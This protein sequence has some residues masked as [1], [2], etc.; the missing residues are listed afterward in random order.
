MFGQSPELLANMWD[1]SRR[2][3]RKAKTNLLKCESSD[4]LVIFIPEDNLFRP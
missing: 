4:Y 2:I 3:Q 1:L